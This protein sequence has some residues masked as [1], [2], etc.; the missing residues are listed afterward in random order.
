MELL[1]GL[2]AHIQ[3]I[4][5][6]KYTMQWHTT[7]FK[8]PFGMYDLS[9]IMTH[10]IGIQK[11]RIILVWWGRCLFW[12]AYPTQLLLSIM[13]DSYLFHVDS[14]CVQRRK[15]NQYCWCLAFE[16][17]CVSYTILLMSIGGFDRQTRDKLRGYCKKFTIICT[18]T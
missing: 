7:R 15:P 13:F 5:N 2:R 11:E 14:V 18:M 17:T 16:T 9:C 4:V 10:Y 8:K 12:S 3:E 1:D 6:S